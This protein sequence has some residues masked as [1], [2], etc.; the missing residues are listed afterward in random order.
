MLHPSAAQVLQSNFSCQSFVPDSSGNSNLSEFC[1]P[2]LDAQIRRAL[3][4]ESSN[5]PDIAALWA[6]AD[7]T[8][9]N[10]A[11]AVA[12]TTNTDTHLVSP[13]VGNYQYSY[14]QGVLLDQLWV[15]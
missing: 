2:A 10:Q 5:A 4:A 8:A 13:R 6:Q 14:S 7:Q 15:R 1:D 9:T 3:A 11:P 12:L